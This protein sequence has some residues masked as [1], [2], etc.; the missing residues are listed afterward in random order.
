MHEASRLPPF[1]VVIWDGDTIQLWSR[2]QQDMCNGF[3]ILKDFWNFK[4][5]L[6]F[7][8]FLGFREFQ[9]FG[10]SMISTTSMISMISRLQLFGGFLNSSYFEGVSK[11]QF[12]T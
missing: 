5:F 12:C 4:Q 11:P 3:R 1:D 7:L 9:R 6:R 8:R 10:N 2:I